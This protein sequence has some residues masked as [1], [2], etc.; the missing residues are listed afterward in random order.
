MEAAPIPDTTKTRAM[1]WILEGVS[2]PQESSPGAREP[3]VAP[4]G[5][6]NSRARDRLLLALALIGA[7]S[8]A[9]GYW[10]APVLECPDPY[11]PEGKYCGLAWWFFTSHLVVALGGAVAGLLGASMRRWLAALAGLVA[12]VLVGPWIALAIA[13]TA[14]GNS[15]IFGSPPRL[16]TSAWL[17]FG[18][19]FSVV[20]A[21]GFSVGYAIGGAVARAVRSR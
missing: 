6:A 11:T 8:S 3:G 7:T 18:V 13:I 15:P 2:G 16:D 9:V 14:P 21:I 1:G 12:G 17:G 10:V 4:A 20:G 19:I 5:G